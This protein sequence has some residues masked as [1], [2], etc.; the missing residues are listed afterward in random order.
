MEINKERGMNKI[1][2]VTR[3][4]RLTELVNKYNPTMY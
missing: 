1:I 3:K 2:I 4:T